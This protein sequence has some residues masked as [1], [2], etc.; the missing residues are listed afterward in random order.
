V[1]AWSTGLSGDA[2]YVVVVLSE[3]PDTELGIR[4]LF[5]ALEAG[6]PVILWDQRPVHTA[7]STT[8]ELRRLTAEPAALP[9]HMRALRVAAAQRAE[10]EPD[11][12]GRSVALLWDDPNRVVAVG[13]AGS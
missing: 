3:P 13:G 6:V 12:Y 2:S 5:A 8:D 7:G 10:E 11:H 4:E 9:A 1:D